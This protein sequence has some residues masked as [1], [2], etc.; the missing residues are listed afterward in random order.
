MHPGNVIVTSDGPRLIDWDGATRAPVGLDLASCHVIN[1]EVATEAVADP[2]RPRANN[3]A[4]QSEYARQAG[5]S[6]AA[7]TAAMEPYLSIILRFI[8]LGRRGEPP[9]PARAADTARGSDPAVAGQ[10]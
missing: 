7:L 3:A 2:E 8:L 5:I 6:L 10:D 1:S 4:M 9:W